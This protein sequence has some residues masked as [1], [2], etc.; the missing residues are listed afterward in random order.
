M[1]SN[2]IGGSWQGDG[3]IEEIST[4]RARDFYIEHRD[5]EINQVM[6]SEDRENSSSLAIVI[7]VAVVV[8][9]FLLWIFVL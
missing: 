7:V 3:L 5:P 9:V 8:L 2:Q 4:E 6:E 1:V